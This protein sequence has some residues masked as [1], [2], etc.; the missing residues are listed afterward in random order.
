MTL[1]VKAIREFANRSQ[2]GNEVEFHEL[3]TDAM[4]VTDVVCS[5]TSPAH[6]HFKN[7]RAGNHAYNQWNVKAHSITMQ[8]SFLYNT[9]MAGF[10]ISSDLSY[11]YQGPR[12]NNLLVR[13]NVFERMNG[14]IAITPYIWKGPGATDVQ[15]APSAT[16]NVTIVDNIVWANETHGMLGDW[17][18]QYTFDLHAITNLTVLNNSFHL[19]PG[20]RQDLPLIRLCNIRDAVFTD[21]RVQQTAL[22]VNHPGVDCE[23][24]TCL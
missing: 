3:I 22:D 14:A 1:T 10:D 5:T 13:N 24:V 16:H 17:F 19:T 21:N 15:A 7:V 9:T 23:F 8:D 12:A 20:M 6:I 4:Q 11:W 2:C 18:Q